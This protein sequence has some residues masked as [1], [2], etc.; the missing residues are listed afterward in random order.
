VPLHGYKWSVPVNPAGLAK[1]YLTPAFAAL[2]YLTC[3]DTIC[4]T[5]L[6]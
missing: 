2:G 1:H 3:D 4:A 5:R 6:L